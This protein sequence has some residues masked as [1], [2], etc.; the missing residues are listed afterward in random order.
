MIAAGAAEAARGS[1]AA[2]RPGRR[3][4]GRAWQP[5]RRCVT[6][7]LSAQAS[8][9]TPGAILLTVRRRCLVCDFLEERVEPEDTDL[10]GPPCTRCHAPSER[11]EVLNRRAVPHQP[12][13]HAAALGRLGGLKGGPARAAAL[14]A[15]RRRAIAKAAA[16]ARWNKTGVVREPRYR[17]SASREPATRDP[18][19]HFTVHRQSGGRMTARGVFCA[20]AV[21]LV[22]AAPAARGRQSADEA[23]IK[24]ARAIHDKVI[25]LDTHVD[26]NPADFTAERNYTQRLDT[27]VN[28]PKMVEG[29]LDAVFLIVYVGQPSLQSTPDAFEPSGYERA[30]KAA[31]EKFDAMHRLT[32][33]IAPDK[34]GLALTAADV[35][36]IAASGRKVA[37]IGVENGYPLGTDISRVKEFY[38]RGA[39]YMSLAHNGHS[40]LSDSNTGEAEGWKWNG[41]SPLGKQVI[42]EM[43]RV[44]IMIDVSHPSKESM[45]QAMQI[46][47][48][49][50]IASHS[51]ARALCNHSRNL[52]D[53]QLLALKKN[54]GVMQTVAFAT[55]VK[56]TD[57]PERAAALDAL[58][59]EFG[60]PAGTPLGGRGGRGG[61]GRGGAPA[62]GQRRRM[63]ERPRCGARGAAAA[64]ALAVAVHWR[65]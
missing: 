60:L 43:N 13:P 50:I 58:R 25:A 31:I 7:F 32:E 18:L 64:R 24:K 52:D 6:L 11:I 2:K 49:P 51:A 41:L 44:G 34:I 47:K 16:R 4:N 46:S 15:R 61:R 33:T 3:R 42:A 12:N 21:S 57:T 39:R 65:S 29:G 5:P 20:V 9:E 62:A 63:P 35:R 45:M 53:E 54:G 40:Q 28:L 22:V 59:K 56:S 48:A 23:L 36:R 38:D 37:L 8:W 30:Y 55:Y 27:Q 17:D 26:I 14:S 10:I 1:G 19:I